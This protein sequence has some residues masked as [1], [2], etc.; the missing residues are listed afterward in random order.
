MKKK[1]CNS[2]RVF[3]CFLILSFLYKN[4]KVFSQLKVQEL[5]LK[6][7]VKP[8]EV[9][10]LSVD[11]SYDN[12]DLS[13]GVVQPQIP[14]FTI[15]GK[16]L[17]D[18]ISLNY[19]SGSGIRVNEDASDVGLGWDLDAGGYIIR[20]VKGIPDD[21][22][23][24]PNGIPDYKEGDPIPKDEI[25]FI[26]GQSLLNGWLDHA[27][28]GGTIYHG[29]SSQAPYALGWPV[30]PLNN[31]TVGDE[32]NNFIKNYKNGVIDHIRYRPS[33]GPSLGQDLS[34]IT[35]AGAMLEV[36]MDGQ[37]DVFHFKCPGGYS[38][39][40]IFDE[41]GI[42][43]P[44]PYNP[45]VKISSPIGPMANNEGKWIITVENGMKFYFPHNTNYYEKTRTETS[46]SPV[47]DN[48][49][50][51]TPDIDESIHVSEYI[52]K[53]Y[54]SRAESIVGSTLDY[55]YVNEPDFETETKVSVQQD[56]Y[57]PTH[58]EKEGSWIRTTPP[59]NFS[60][61][62]GST[63]SRSF[64]RDNKTQLS[65]KK[66]L[67]QINSSNGS[68]I[69]FTY[70]GVNREDIKNQKH[71][72]GNISLRDMNNNEVLQYIFSYSYFNTPSVSGHNGKRL[73]LSGLSKKKNGGALHTGF[74]KFNYYDSLILPEKNSHQQD[75]WGYFNANSVNT[76]IPELNRNAG[77]ASRRDL[78][79]GDRSP[80]ELRAKSCM[81]KEI[82]FPTGGSIEYD[83]ELN[84]YK[85]VYG[86]VT[87]G[88]K[89]VPTGGLRIK[90]IK[91]KEVDNN[92]IV[93]NFKYTL[94]GSPDQSSGQIP[95]H[96]RQW[97]GN[98]AGRLY[99]K[100]KLHLVPRVSPPYNGAALY[101]TRYSY[102]K[103][104]QA[105]DLIRYSHVVI[106][107]NGGG[108]TEYRLTAFDDYPDEEK[109][110]IHWESSEIHSWNIGSNPPP[111]NVLYPPSDFIEYQ[112]TSNIPGS[113]SPRPSNN[114]SD[115]S[116]LRGL[117]LNVKEYKEND[118]SPVRETL[119]TF[120]VNPDGFQVRKIYAIDSNSSDDF[121]GESNNA[122]SL[123]FDI[124]S[125]DLDVV[126][127]HKKEIKE[128]FTDSQN[129]IT[130]T[131]KYFYDNL[132]NHLQQT[133]LEVTNSKGEILKT[134]TKYPHDVNNARLIQEN[135]IVEPLEV[136]N[137]RDDKLLSHQKIIYNDNHNPSSI[138]LPEIIQLL[139]G[140][141]NLKDRF[142]Y[143][144]YDSKGNPVEIGKKDGTHVVYIWGYNKTEPIAKIENATLTQVSSYIDNIQVKSN[145]DNDRTIGNL[146][147]EGALRIALN[148]LR[149]I[150]GLSNAQI[151][152]YT[153]DPLI[154]VTS[155][156]DPRGET[157]YYSYDDY[158]R[159]KSIK[160]SQGKILKE[161]RYNYKN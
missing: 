74:Y 44:I 37:P 112:E 52:S 15:G 152:T 54:I 75:F 136:L 151:T 100:E 87:F 41:K 19:I 21:A 85:T 123:N 17:F 146:G 145:E 61:G 93:K 26:N 141:E 147:K 10:S 122:Y 96:L 143:Y 69:I 72:L 159:L 135:R 104:L 88:W 16:E 20:E 48:W 7:N 57:V 11:I 119:N 142:V 1:L 50:R 66:R 138:Y 77:S 33:Y 59:G 23:I 144:N 99:D 113:R 107:I 158:N 98:G 73:M 35:A 150:P 3:Y 53:W 62:Y 149:V 124:S 108:K 80:N 156:T 28:W 148:N 32:I 153:Y 4:Q 6:V 129:S 101:I 78:S 137:Y 18:K 38:G 45:N 30:K 111:P 94:P 134:E 157:T 56:F 40:F 22:L 55:L 95:V 36:V 127:L 154:G 5:Q 25:Q 34:D 49:F 160:D 2:R 47:R 161:Y 43:T 92:P 83:Y 103:Y 91:E 31:K 109:T 81:L 76:L 12:V 130:T 42:P 133:R 110:K 65:Y 79:G 89:K 86:S 128:Y 82:I 90:S 39:K 8:P 155:I 13:K 9:G 63:T 120:T 14:F 29:S 97:K 46:N 71:S 58:Y 121:F 106:D 132:I 116:H 139:K 27:N 118:A 114:L 51:N 67:S 115:K 70:N 84:D 24:W 140:S 131:N 125:H 64:N 60:S 105:S 117:I 68:K 126:Y 102:A